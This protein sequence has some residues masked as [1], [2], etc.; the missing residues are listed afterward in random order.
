M[1]EGDLNEQE[2]KPKFLQNM[3]VPKTPF[4]LIQYFMVAA[5]WIHAS[6]NAGMMPGS[7]PGDTH[8]EVP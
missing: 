2:G 4:L 8:L 7:E 1:A 6:D 5:Q 3:S